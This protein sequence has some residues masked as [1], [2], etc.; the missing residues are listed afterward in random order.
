MRSARLIILTACFGLIVLPLGMLAVANLYEQL[1]MRRYENTLRRAAARAL[2]A[3]P[4]ALTEIGRSQGVE[5]VVL[6]GQGRE[7]ARS[8]SGEAAF[9]ESAF[10]L[11]TEYLL[12]RAGQPPARE[13][14]AEL[15]QALGPPAQREEVRRALAGEGSFTRRFSPS[16]ETVVFTLAVPR[17][18]GGAL[19]GLKASRRGIRRLLALQDELLK[20]TFY[21]LGFG[22]AVAALLVRWLVRPLEQLAEGAEG[23]PRR[24]LATPGLLVRKDELGRLARAFSSLARSLEQRRQATVDLA[25]DVAHEFKNPLATIAASAELLASQGKVTPER[26]ALATQH[27]SGAVERLRINT[28]ALLALVRLE[29]A[30][31]HTRREQVDYAALVRAV[32]EEYQG[33]PRYADWSLHADISPETGRVELVPEAWGR[34][35]RNLMDNAL[36]QPSERREVIL[37]A[38]RLPGSLVT[39]VQDFGPGISVGNRDKVFRR[40]FTS[41]PVGA[42]PGTGLG[43]S[44]VQAVAEAHGGRVEFDSV[45]GQGATFRVVIPA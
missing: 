6:D 32:L 11:L 21:Q 24:P 45:P 20:L 42:P 4:A 23:Y 25:A 28:D 35:L 39:E 41:R 15:E 29:A 17:P 30:L 22:V 12:T 8:H 27:I 10:G 5:L 1:L 14:M 9:S 3:E 33:D 37:R 7:E 13:S 16:G 31:P 40:F 43:L 34:L 36:V 26:L 19:Q 38:H 44:I 2:A 18:E